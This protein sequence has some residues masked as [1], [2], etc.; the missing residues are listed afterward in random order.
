MI[1]SEII[2]ANTSTS[3][4]NECSLDNQQL[5][6]AIYYDINIPTGTRK[7][8]V[9]LCCSVERNCSKKFHKNSQ[10]GSKSLCI[11]IVN[12]KLLMLSEKLRKKTST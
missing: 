1:R 4:E 7:V 6:I 10:Y 8:H 3:D 5:F 2:R 12:D 9:K 11:H